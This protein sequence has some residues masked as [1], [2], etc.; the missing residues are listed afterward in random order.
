MPSNRKLSHLHTIFLFFIPFAALSVSL[1]QLYF[2]DT[3][4]PHPIT[5]WIFSHA[6][7][8]AQKNERTKERERENRHKIVTAYTKQLHNNSNNS[9]I[10]DRLCICGLID[11]CLF[12]YRNWT[13]SSATKRRFERPGMSI[14]VKISV[15]EIDDILK[16]LLNWDY[17]CF[18][19]STHFHI[20]MSYSSFFFYTFQIIN[21]SWL[22]SFMW[23]FRRWN[24]VYSFW[25]PY[26]N[27]FVY[28]DEFQQILNMVEV[29]RYRKSILRNVLC[30]KE[31]LIIKTKNSE[32]S[33]FSLFPYI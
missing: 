32:C 31:N 11:L 12:S 19:I 30:E 1:Q 33:I 18:P 16:L 13:F 26:A 29:E 21:S 23:K 14:S 8:E 24:I 20:N 7:K 4:T 28:I 22:F 17:F 15:N 2:I 25:I 6:L 5:L 3:F 27:A 9:N 10:S